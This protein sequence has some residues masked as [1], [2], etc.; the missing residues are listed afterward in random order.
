MA[1][2]AL[3]RQQAIIATRNPKWRWPMICVGSALLRHPFFTAVSPVS[4]RQAA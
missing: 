2:G 4:A 3:L 1:E